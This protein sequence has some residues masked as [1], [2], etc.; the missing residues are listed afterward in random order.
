M[1]TVSLPRYP[2]DGSSPLDS[3]KSDTVVEAVLREEE[4]VPPDRGQ[5]MAWDPVKREVA[6]SATHPLP[7]NGGVLATAGELDRY[8][9]TR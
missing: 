2:K 8:R 7:F 6:W 9:P 1:F 3:R 5:L 4:S